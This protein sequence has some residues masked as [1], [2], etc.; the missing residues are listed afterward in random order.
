[1]RPQPPLDIHLGALHTTEW[2][3][4][5][6]DIQAFGL[7]A[8]QSASSDT[9]GVGFGG[10]QSCGQGAKVAPAA[11]A[12]AAGSAAFKAKM[13]S[14]HDKSSTNLYMEGCVFFSSRLTRRQ[15]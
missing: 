10:D 7:A 9:G 6:I 1:M 12:A 3:A 4:S 14:L 11:A 2:D 15:S 13:E 8:G 5:P